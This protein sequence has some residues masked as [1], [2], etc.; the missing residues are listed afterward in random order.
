MSLLSQ[1]FK[2]IFCGKPE[3]GEAA[4]DEAEGYVEPITPIP[5]P[6]PEDTTSVAEEEISPVRPAAPPPPRRTTR[7]MAKKITD[8]FEQSQFMKRCAFQNAHE[9][10]AEIEK[11]IDEKLQK[12]K[13]GG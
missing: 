3:N 12:K 10:M 13:N 9:R 4:L 1:W 5:T 7:K 2:R 8:D 6:D 11:K